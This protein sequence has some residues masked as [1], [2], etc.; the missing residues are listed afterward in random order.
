MKNVFVFLSFF[1][2]VVDCFDQRNVWTFPEEGEFSRTYFL[3]RK[4]RE[5]IKSDK[6]YFPAY[7]PV[8]FKA[9]CVCVSYHGFAL[10]PAMWNVTVMVCL[11]P[12]RLG[13]V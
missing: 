7:A 4:K 2:R 11:S 13:W 1:F 5:M 8:N 9:M 3:T 12:V 10:D 6:Y